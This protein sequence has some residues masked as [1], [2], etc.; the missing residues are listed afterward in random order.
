MKASVGHCKAFLFD[1]DGTLVDSLPIKLSNAG[2]VFARHLGANK[3]EVEEAYSRHSGLPRRQLFNLISNDCIGRP[4]TDGEFER[5]SADFT[6]LNR[7]LIAARAKL[8]PETLDAL[9]RLTEQGRMV[10]ISTATAQDEI[11]PLAAGFGI[12]RYCTEVMGSRA[13][14]TKGP[15]HAEHVASQYGLTKQ[16]IVGVGD[17]EQDMRLFR[18]AG[19]TAVGIVGTRSRSELEAAGADLVIE[20]LNEVILNGE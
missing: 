3:Q 4:M 14:F 17:D 19:I 9:A 7:S 8:R 1:W 6:Q 2:E 18:E 12:T 20:K 13:G 10:F 16:E 5:V 15:V 11:D